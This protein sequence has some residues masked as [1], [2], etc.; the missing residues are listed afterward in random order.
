VH[1]EELGKAN[2][3]GR[4]GKDLLQHAEED[5]G[6]CHFLESPMATILIEYVCEMER[7]VGTHRGWAND[8]CSCLDILDR[9]GI[10]VN[11]WIIGDCRVLCRGIN[12]CQIGGLW[13]PHSWNREVSVVMGLLVN[14]V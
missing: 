3:Q 5:R 2:Y 10:V 13:N 11:A 4:P 7:K 9:S 14:V 6:K 8:L 1:Q 12:R